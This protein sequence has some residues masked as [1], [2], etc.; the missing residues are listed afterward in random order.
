MTSIT[1]FHIVTG[2]IA[3]L[4][5]YLALFSKKGLGLHRKAGNVYSIFMLCMAVAGIVMAYL[6]P[7]MITVLAGLF[8]SYL[9]AT[10]WMTVKRKQNEI[11]VFEVIALFV[12]LSI[13]AAGIFFGLQAMDSVS[14]LK[15]GFSHEPYFFFGGLAL[16][17]AALDLRVLICRGLNATQRIARHLW[18]MCFALYIAA[19][20]LFTGPGA[21]VFPD[22]IRDK[23]I[24]T[25]PENVVA[26]L[27]LF[28]LIRVLFTKWNKSDQK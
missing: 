1:V 28:W 2:T 8:T 27:M 17:S 7:M 3:V 10:S 12:A 23:F 21:K 5:G 6:K 24:L 26:L 22:S 25:V 11:G 20:S 13:G 19:G 9:V 15:D 18:R 4:S 14:G 16:V